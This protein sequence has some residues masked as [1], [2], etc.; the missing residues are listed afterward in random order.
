MHRLRYR[1][2]SDLA[3]ESAFRAESRNALATLTRLLG[4]LD[5]AE[6]A[7][8]DAFVVALE[9]WPVDGVPDKP[10]A[11]I[12]TIARNK[13][14]DRIRREAKRADK[15]AAAH[16]SLAALDGWDEP[17]H[18]VVRDDV[19]RLVFMC[20]HPVLPIESRVALSLRSLC[21]LSTA[22]VARL[23]LVAEPTMAQRLVRA[24]RRLAEAG[25]VLAIPAAHD[26][27]ER[28]PAVLGT[29]HLLFTEGHNASTGPAHI[30]AECC[31]EAVRLARLLAE[32]MPD[33]PEVVGLLG[34]LL[35]TDARR[36]ARSDDAGDLVLLADQDRSRWDRP[37]IDEGV[38]VIERAL[39]LG[40]AGRYQLEAAIAA[41]HAIAPSIE[42]TDWCEIADLYALLEAIDGDPLVRLNR[43]VAVAE[44][45]GVAAG[46]DVLDGVAGLDTLHLRWSVE[47][48]LRRRNGE[49]GAATAALRRALECSPNDAERRLLERRL[50]D[51]TPSG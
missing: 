15:Q 25:V 38:A 42:A 23:F 28:L 30:R 18:G 46:I 12:T 3:L 22:A 27:T 47:A 35:V 34:L 43:A 19:L 37:M 26:L 10:G 11:W 51:M 9:R 29:I 8:Q 14:L 20:C 31:V 33:E 41:C 36:P 32:L 21:G 45:W 13:A 17:A 50:T 49:V 24:K 40:A 2:L 6:E 39:R 16:R 7:V 5:A 4:S 48:E 44:A 1:G